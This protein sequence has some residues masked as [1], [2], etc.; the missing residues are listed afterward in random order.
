MLLTGSLWTDSINS[1]LIHILYVLYT[2][3]SQ[4]YK[5]EKIYLQYCIVFIY[6]GMFMLSAYKMNF[7]T[8]I[9]ALGC[10]FFIF[11]Y[12]TALG[13]SC[14]RQGLWSWLQHVGCLVLACRIF[15]SCSMLRSRSL[16][17]DWTWPSAL[18]AW[19][20]NHWTIKEVPQQ[21]YTKHCR[22]YM[23][24]ENYTSNMKR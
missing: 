5:L 2:L 14:G 24:Y 11:I 20:L 19:S 18:G 7:N 12:W 6:I 21:S 23:Y 4:Q 10:F 17:K 1:W 8:C 13:L 9:K 3:F 22:Y 16:I 15:F